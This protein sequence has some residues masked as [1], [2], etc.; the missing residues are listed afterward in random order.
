[1]T[2]ENVKNKPIYRRSYTLD[3]DTLAKELK[4]IKNNPLKQ[5]GNNFHDNI[6]LVGSMISLP[7]IISAIDH[8]KHEFFVLGL[9]EGIREGISD[10]VLNF[11]GTN[12]EDLE[13]KADN[14]W[15]TKYEPKRDEIIDKAFQD[16]IESFNKLIE[17]TTLYE[18][19]RSLLYAGIVFTWCSFEVCMKDIWETALN[20]GNK[21]VMKTTLSN[22]N[23]I[24]RINNFSGIQG[25]YINLDYLA[26]YNYNV[27]NK[28]GS[29]LANKFDF[30]SVYGIKDAYLC[31]FPRSATIKKA[32]E[33]K[34]LVQ[35][36]ARRH[37]I[38]HKAGVID[39]TFCKKAN[40]N[41]K[42]TGSKLGLSDEE[43]SGF[44]NVAIDTVIQIIKA[45]STI[46]SVG[47][48]KN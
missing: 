2:E 19:Y 28:L 14:V 8:S 41:K 33:N 40:V 31:A 4:E 15:K 23:N 46:L 20:I 12:E 9:K 30:S 39:D 21:L 16:G 36:E 24:D 6:V 7:E 3:T 18:P 25:K 37:I 34:E 26:Q 47:K 32:L 35:L 38:V 13:E 22:I 11:E 48:V 1:M 29:I 27:T 10:S 5:I 42:L 43:L 45:V 17:N 44:G